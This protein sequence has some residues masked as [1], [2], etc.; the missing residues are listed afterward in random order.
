MQIID[1][2]LVSAYYRERLRRLVF[3]ESFKI[4]LAVVLVGDDPASRIYVSAKT[5]ECREVGIETRDFFLPETTPEKELLMLIDSLNRDEE[6]DGILV[7]LPLPRHIDEF[8]VISSIS[9]LKDVDCFTPENFG[10]LVMGRPVVEP[11]T[12]KGIIR[13]LEYY[14]VEVE[15]KRAVVVGRSN[16]VGKPVSALLLNRNA[17]VTICHSKTRNLSEITKE[18]DILVVAVGK[19]LFVK[20][21]MVKEGSVVIDVGINRLNIDGKS[22]IVGDVD[23][24][25]VK[26]ICSYITPVPGGVGPMTRAMLLENTYQLAVYRRKKH[27]R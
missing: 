15:G 12:A 25:G 17:T 20:R 23:F 27:L 24:E 18:A 13:L 1:G 19:P 5:R 2:N 6:V 8:R 22:K 21:G 14:G 7:Q 26:D 9:P 3:S 16:I 4:T 10:K 11:C